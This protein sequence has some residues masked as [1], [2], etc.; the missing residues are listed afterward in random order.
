M[1]TAIKFSSLP[2]GRQAHLHCIVS[3]GVVK[4]TNSKNDKDFYWKSTQ[5]KNNNFLFPVKA[6]SAVYRAVFLKQLKRLIKNNKLKLT[7]A[8]Q[9]QLPS[10]IS[11]LYE[12]QWVV[13]AKKPFGGPGQVLQYLAAYTHKVAIS[14]HRIISTGDGKVTFT[15][16][17]YQDCNKQKQMSLPATEFLRRFEQHILPKGFT[18]IRTYGYPAN[19][20]RTALLKQ[21]TAALKLPAHPQKIKVPWQV[22][23]YEAYGVRYNE[24]T[25]CKKLSL[26]LV[27]KNFR[28]IE[29]DST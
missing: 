19:R 9:Q 16:K 25:C 22:L 29:L 8:Q 27:K 6:L 23:L 18:K 28:E 12:K 7:A 5:R 1:G 26:V 4:K 15:Y 2:T 13:Y 20:G 10:L 3:G 21:I 11:K 24:C 14:N 17:D